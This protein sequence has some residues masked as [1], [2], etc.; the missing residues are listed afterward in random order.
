MIYDWYEVWA[1][2]TPNIPYLVILCPHP[3]EKGQFIIIDPME[4][5]RITNIF[6]DYDSAKIW[7]LE[8]ECTMVKGRMINEEM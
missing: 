6:S 2:E 3:I 8:D 1:E 4:N 7:L 5:N